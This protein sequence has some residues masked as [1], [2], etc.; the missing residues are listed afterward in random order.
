MTTNTELNISNAVIL[1]RPDGSLVARFEIAGSV[2]PV[3]YEVPFGMVSP[4]SS[5]IT[6][7]TPFVACASHI[8]DY[9]FDYVES[10]K[11]DVVNMPPDIRFTFKQKKNNAD[12]INFRRALKSLIDGYN[13]S[14]TLFSL[15]KEAG[16]DRTWTLA[17]ESIESLNDLIERL[18]SKQTQVF[19]YNR[20][21]T[22]LRDKKPINDNVVYL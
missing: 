21:K 19:L 16:E 17:A 2:L 6:I 9:F 4:D 10:V 22:T 18:H 14:Q 15:E 20:T 3:A 5:T 12:A 13:T 8:P 1:Q 11:F 7:A